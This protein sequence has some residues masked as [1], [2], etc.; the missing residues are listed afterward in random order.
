MK[1][2]MIRACEVNGINNRSKNAKLNQST[3]YSHVWGGFSDSSIQSVV[4]RGVHV[5]TNFKILVT[6]IL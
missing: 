4:E 6:L 3:K 5:G 2:L 1:K